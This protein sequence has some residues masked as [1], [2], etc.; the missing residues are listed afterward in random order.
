[1]CYLITAFQI[2]SS[3]YRIRSVV[4]HGRHTANYVL[5]P[6]ALGGDELLS[7]YGAAARTGRADFRHVKSSTQQTA[8]A[9]ERIWGKRSCRSWRRVNFTIFAVF[10]CGPCLFSCHDTSRIWNACG[11]S[12]RKRFGST[13]S[14]NCTHC[15]KYVMWCTV[16]KGTAQDCI[17][18]MWR[19]HKVPLSVKVVNLARFFPAWTVTR[20]Q[21]ADMMMLGDVPRQVHP[22]WSI[23]SDSP[24]PAWLET[25]GEED[26][27]CLVDQ[28]SV[29]SAYLNLDALSSLSEE[30]SQDSAE[31]S[32]L[33]VTL[34]C[35]S[36]EAGTRVNS[37]QVSSDGDFPAESGT[38]DKRQVVRRCASP[39]SGQIIGTARDDRQYEPPL[40][41]VDLVTGKCKPG[42][43][44]R[45]VSTTPLTLDLTVVCTSSAVVPPPGVSLNA[46]LPPATVASKVIDVG[47]STPV[48]AALAPVVEQPGVHVVELPKPQLPESPK[49]L[50]LSGQSSSSPS[51]TLPWGAADD[52]SPPFL[53][54][55]RRCTLRMFRT[56]AVCLMCRRFRQDSS[57]G[58]HEGVSRLRL[59]GSCCQRRWTTLMIRLWVIRSLMRSVNS[60]PLSL[61]VYAWPSG[62][63]FLLDPTVLQNV[64]ASGTSALPAEGTSAAAPLMDLGDDRLLE[65]GLPGC[66]YRFSESGGL[67]FTDGNSAYGYS[68]II[69]GFW[70]SSE[71]RS[72]PGSSTVHRRSG[73]ISWAR[74]KR[75]QRP[76]TYIDM[77]ASCCRIFRYC[78]SSLWR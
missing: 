35:D 47:T 52:S 28:M 15:G 44:S 67:P 40:P 29:S 50:P 24:A 5:E 77:R 56:R 76:S 21:W 74:N 64:L 48:V 23:A 25:S 27:R 6:T 75:W 69:L 12:A 14:G 4:L 43:V 54:V 10:G 20:E 17:D 13:Q 26:S 53:Q 71:L 68:F 9:F 58:H 72:R 8:M 51:P 42:K 61:P 66:P 36:D 19:I 62:S 33:S 1:M 11:R 57:F 49:L 70:S 45:T 16:L 73:W 55:F 41:V 30:D 18:H 3:K 22:A 60:F 7:R 32:G 34:F 65:T 59:R 63:A 46:V 37:D 38:K 39:P 78:H 31:R 2:R